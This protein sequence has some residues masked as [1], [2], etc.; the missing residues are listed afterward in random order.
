MDFS[1]SGRVRG[2]ERFKKLNIRGEDQRGIPVCGCKREVPVFSIRRVRF[3]FYTCRKNEVRVV[4]N[5]IVPTK[6]ISI[7][8]GILFDDRSERDRLD[9]PGLVI[10]YG[11]FQCKGEGGERF[12]SACR[13]VKGEDP[14]FC[15][16]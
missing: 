4:F 11:M 13:D 1:G 6:N 3:Y 9:Y 14:R 10:F 16:S 7:D 5:N 8:F 12:S 15:L 2:K